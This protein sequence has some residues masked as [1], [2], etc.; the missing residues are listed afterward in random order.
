MHWRFASWIELLYFIMPKAI[1]ERSSIHGAS[2][3]MPFGAIHYGRANNLCSSFVLARAHSAFALFFANVHR[4]LERDLRAGR[5]IRPRDRS[6]C[7]LCSGCRA[8]RRETYAP[9]IFKR[10][11][12]LFSQSA[13]AVQ[14]LARLLYTKNSKPCFFSWQKYPRV[15]KWMLIK[16]TLR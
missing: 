6:L 16:N 12:R 2:Q 11:I 7:V 10:K 9:Q 8:A 13:A 15:V 3:F 14:A 5:C 1:H 4:P